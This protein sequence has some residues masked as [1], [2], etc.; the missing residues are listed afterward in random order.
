MDI[1]KST[2]MLTTFLTLS[3]LIFQLGRHSHKIDSI[4]PKI[5]ALEEE[6]EYITKSIGDINI[7]LS[8]IEERVINVDKE[9]TYIRNKMD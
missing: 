9:V 3:G 6:S 2:K 4:F 5:Y 7:K 8:T 1:L